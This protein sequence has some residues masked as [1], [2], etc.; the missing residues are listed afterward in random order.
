M[1]KRQRNVFP[2]AQLCH[3]FAAGTQA[4]GRGSHLFFEGDTIYSY[5]THYPM[6][7]RY[8]KGTGK[9]YQEY[10]LINSYGYSSSTQ[11][12]HSHLNRAIRGRQIYTIHVPYPKDLKRP[13][14]EIHLINQIADSIGHTLSNNWGTS[15]PTEAIGKLNIYYYLCDSDTRFKL[16]DD[17]WH[18]INTINQ[19][20][21]AKS[22]ERDKAERLER[23]L[24]L[25]E[26][27]EKHAT[28]VKL[29]STHADTEYIPRSAFTFDHVRITRAGNEV[30]TSSG[31]RVPLNHAILGLARLDSGKTITGLRLGH[32]TVESEP[33]AEGYFKV[34]CHRLNINQ[35]REV[36][37]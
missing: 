8:R 15:N 17:T 30:E 29:W 31:A 5:G 19:A 36:L 35:I 34:G 26:T 24:K 11:R 18:V 10:M 27:I 2:N 32:F 21:I 22:L 4:S 6:A 3:V 25:K 23:E 12:H 9:A 37:G 7:T 20:K 16:D 13:D 1:A 14:N 33:D 28:E